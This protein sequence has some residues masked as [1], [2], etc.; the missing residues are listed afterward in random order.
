MFLWSIGEAFDFF[1]IHSAKSFFE[2][3]ADLHF[4]CVETFIALS[5][6]GCYDV[7]KQVIKQ[8]QGK[9]IFSYCY[10]AITE[11]F[12]TLIDKK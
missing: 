8:N 12:Q 6:S 4:I 2:F 9:H 10:S 3:P 1:Q 7:M 11:R 5:A